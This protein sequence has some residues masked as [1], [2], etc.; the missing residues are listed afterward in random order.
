MPTCYRSLFYEAI[1]KFYGTVMA[2]AESF[3]KRPDGGTTSRWQPFYGQEHLVLL[4]FDSLQTSGFFT[5]VQELADAIAKLGKLS[6]P[7]ADISLSAVPT[8]L[9]GRWES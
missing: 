6:Y 1:D 3:R 4:G 8:K 7:A 5:Q 2:Q 9:P